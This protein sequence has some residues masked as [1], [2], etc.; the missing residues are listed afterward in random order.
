MFVSNTF[1]DKLYIFSNLCKP[2]HFIP[3]GKWKPSRLNLSKYCPEFETLLQ[4]PFFESEIGCSSARRDR[5]EQYLS[6][7]SKFNLP[8]LL[9]R[10]L[11]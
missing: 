6:L 7:F 3:F 9:K 10:N 2:L 1:M 8:E 5:K 4:C 11:T